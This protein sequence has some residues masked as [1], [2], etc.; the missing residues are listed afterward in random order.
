MFSGKAR[1]LPCAETQCRVDRLALEIDQRRG[2][3]QIE[4]KT[5]MA[6]HEGG[7][8]RHQPARRERWQR[9]QG[10]R[11]GG[12]LAYAREY[13]LDTVDMCGHIVEQAFAMRGQR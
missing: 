1:P 2:R 11:V 7:Q 12:P 3:L 13:T 4:F 8:A 5:W 9:T 6:R 10:Q